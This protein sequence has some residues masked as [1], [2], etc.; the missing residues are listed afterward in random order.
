MAQATVFK[1]YSEQQHSF[2]TIKTTISSASVLALPNFEKSFNADTDASA[3]CIGVVLSQ[4]VRPI[5]F[6]SEKECS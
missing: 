4:E 2:D 6:F 5:E 3:I 1:W